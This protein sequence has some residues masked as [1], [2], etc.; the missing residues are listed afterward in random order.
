M[1]DI[2]NDDTFISEL[3]FTFKDSDAANT[4]R[5]SY[6]LKNVKLDSESFSSS[7]G[8]NKTVDLTFSVSIGGPTDNTNNVFFSGSN[9]TEPFSTTR[10]GS[11]SP[12]GGGFPQGLT[13]GPTAYS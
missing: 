12:N 8:P 6:K 11:D 13:K 1:T 7:I 10:D 5:A 9:A 3:Q 2:I 4:P